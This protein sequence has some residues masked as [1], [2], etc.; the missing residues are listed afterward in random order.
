MRIRQWF[1]ASINRKI[2]GLFVLLLSFLFVV[3]LYSMIRLHA[4]DKEIRQISTLDIPIS[5]LVTQVEM[6]Q[7]RQ[8]LLFEKHQLNEGHLDDQTKLALW[9]K[10]QI[11]LLL[12]QAMGMIKQKL[13]QDTVIIDV[14]LHR[15]LLLQLSE[16]QDKSLQFEDLLINILKSR[17]PSEVQLDELERRA[18]VLDQEAKLLLNTIQQFTQDAAFN[19]FKQE[20]QFVWVNGL[21]GVA[22]LLSGLYLTFSV[23][24]LIKTRIGRLKWKVGHLYQAIDNNRAIVDDNN[25]FLCL[26]TQ[27]VSNDDLGELEQDLRKLMHRLSDEIT[28]RKAI[29]AQL[30]ELATLDKLTQVYNRHQWDEHLQQALNTAKRGGPLSLI[31]ID[32]DHFKAINDNH[33]HQVGDRCLTMLASVLKQQ[34]RGEE[35][36]YRIGGEEFSIILPG[37][38]QARA[39]VLAERLR[40]AV[41]SMPF[42]PS[43]TISLGLGQYQQKEP[44]EQ[45]ISRVDNALY[46]AK[47]LGRNRICIA[48]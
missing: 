45:W 35:H 37:T 9:Q 22:A 29:E 7:L 19:T 47:H 12:Q 6:I 8:H 28:S 48:Q 1:N 15:N 21:L 11:K 40:S 10:H 38:E 41:E 4:I 14:K 18:V 44:L 31:L 5:H 17:Q 16:Y 23:I 24:L 46:Q 36:L 26:D 30:I 3:I 33:G 20:H 32:I 13:A 25:A 43:V 34:L 27:R 39:Q 2:S 42:T